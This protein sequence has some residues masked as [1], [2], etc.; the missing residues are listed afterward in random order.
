MTG[1]Q[2]SLTTAPENDQYTGLKMEKFLRNLGTSELTVIGGYDI[3][4]I[5]KSFEK[6][7][8]R[9]KKGAHIILV[10][11]E[12]ALVVKRRAKEIWD[13][14][15]GKEKGEELYIH[16]SESCPMCHE[17]FQRFGCTAIKHLKKEGRSIY[18]IDE[19]AC[20]REHCQACLDV[21]PNH[22][23]DKII[24]NPEEEQNL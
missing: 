22:S 13:L 14:P 3:P 17:C 4:K 9:K 6:I 1:H 21:C 20:M 24:I 19:S 23:I 12:C 18:A 8:T 15:R 11:A 16:I 7:F 2:P 10:N 5:E